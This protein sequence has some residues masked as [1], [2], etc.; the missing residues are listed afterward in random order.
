MLFLFFFSLNNPGNLGSII[1]TSAWFGI[2]T[3][4]CTNDSVDYYN[5]KVVQG[6]MGSL[7]KVTVHYASVN[8]FLEKKKK[9]NYAIIATVPEKGV[10]SLPKTEKN[11][12]IILFG[13][14]SHGIPKRILE[15]FVTLRY[16]IPKISNANAVESLNIGVA[17]GITIH[18]YL[19][20]SL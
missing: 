15:N 5:P 3:I 11:K 14:E 8:E 2:K 4:L 20:F 19:P 17:F 18:K 1:R 6:T 10:V 16:T 13:S 12:T 7:G 9:E